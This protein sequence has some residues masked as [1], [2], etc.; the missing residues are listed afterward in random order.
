MSDMHRT[1]VEQQH[2]TV[3]GRLKPNHQKM[4]RKVKGNS[5]SANM[6]VEW[7][8]RKKNNDEEDEEARHSNTVWLWTQFGRE[9]RRHGISQK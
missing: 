2:P 4:S 5:D 8:K 3:R 9:D 6:K 7:R 1:E